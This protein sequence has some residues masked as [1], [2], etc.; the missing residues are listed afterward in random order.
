M[1]HQNKKDNKDAATTGGQGGD[2]AE[3]TL[4]PDSINKDKSKDSNKNNDLPNKSNASSND[5]NKDTGNP[6]EA[7]SASMTADKPKLVNWATNNGIPT[8][9]VTDFDSFEKVAKIYADS[10]AGRKE[11]YTDCDINGRKQKNLAERLFD[12]LAKYRKKSNGM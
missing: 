8:D 4:N 3:A 9:W 10:D 1:A 11:F 2:N 6:S 12:E 5:P 7:T